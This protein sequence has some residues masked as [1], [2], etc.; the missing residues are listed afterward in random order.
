MK[1]RIG[2]YSIEFVLSNTARGISSTTNNA[3]KKYI[4]IQNDRKFEGVNVFF[5]SDRYDCFAEKGC[6]CSKCGIE[7]KYF[8]LEGQLNNRERRYHFNLYALDENGKE[9]LMTKDHMKPKSKGG[10]DSIDNYDTLCEKCN[11]KKSNK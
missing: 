8:A 1:E 4:K 11:S 6:N 9:V 5:A 7:G 2:I 3:E 10:N